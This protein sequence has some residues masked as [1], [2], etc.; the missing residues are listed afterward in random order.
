MGML[1]ALSMLCSVARYLTYSDVETAFQGIRMSDD[2]ASN[3][4]KRWACVPSSWSTWPLFLTTMLAL[5]LH[6]RPRVFHQAQSA[7][8]LRSWITHLS[9][10]NDQPSVA[11]PNQSSLPDS[12]SR[13]ARSRAF[14]IPTCWCG[15]QFFSNGAS[16][17]RRS[18]TCD[19][20]LPLSQMTR[21]VA[22]RE[23]HEMR[24]PMAAGLSRHQVGLLFGQD[25][26]LRGRQN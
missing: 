6:R 2:R 3:S 15:H 22:A 8:F 11:L 19:V 16:A 18:V 10:G 4:A 17:C 7:N 26:I 5:C 25:G 14:D 9:W 1:F 21:T 13:R 24:R 12:A 20:H 23:G